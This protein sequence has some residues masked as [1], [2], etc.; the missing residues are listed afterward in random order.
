MLILHITYSLNLTSLITEDYNSLT[1]QARL[2]PTVNDLRVAID[3]GNLKM[4][5]ILRT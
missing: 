4:V 2:E 3:S 5:Q 1:D